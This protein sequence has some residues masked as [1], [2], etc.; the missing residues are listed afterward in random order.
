MTLTLIIAPDIFGL[1]PAVEELAGQLNA[2]RVIPLDP[3]GDQGG[4]FTNEA[5]AYAH[6][7]QHVGIGGYARLIYN[8]L[9]DHSPD[10]D[11]PE[12]RVLLGFSAGAA[13]LWT[14]ADNHEL[15]EISHCMGYYGSQ[16][17]NHPSIRPLWPVEL[18]FPEKEDH[19]DVGFLMAQL[20]GRKNLELKKEKGK[21]G[22]MNP[23]SP[24]YDAELARVHI[25]YIN[26][27]LETIGQRN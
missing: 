2:H 17:R 19:F 23:H 25:R 15:G 16:I 24:N 22:F 14:L 10:K 13:A 27:R 6:F 26:R 1:T 9:M 12:T 11:A 8:T 20:T 3:Y 4:Y 5:T 18:I 7:T 21:H